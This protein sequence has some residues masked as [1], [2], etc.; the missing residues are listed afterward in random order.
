[1]KIVEPADFFSLFSLA[2][3]DREIFGT[4]TTGIKKGWSGAPVR[5]DK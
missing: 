5:V 2:V 4:P 1:L 3:A